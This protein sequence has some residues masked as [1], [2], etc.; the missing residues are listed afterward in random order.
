M[1]N[2]SVISRIIS[3]IKGDKVAVRENL[4]YD[5]VK[6]NLDFEDDDLI[7]KRTVEAII[8]GGTLQIT[9][10]IVAGTTPNPKTV[11]YSGMVNPSLVFRNLDGSN[12]SGATNNVDNGTDIV[13]TGD[14][15]G[16]GHFADT[17]TFIIKP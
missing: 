6:G 16:T 8:S 9:T 7:N 5:T 15:D 14:D 17:F 4:F 2:E 13:L 10:N 1:K 11:A 3:A 12:Y